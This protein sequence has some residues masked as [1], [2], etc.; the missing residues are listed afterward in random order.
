VY[1]HILTVL[2]STWLKSK[3]QWKCTFKLPFFIVP[4]SNTVQC[5]I[6]FVTWGIWLFYQW[7]D[8]L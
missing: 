4:C 8:W 1:G 7:S 5:R 3:K 2:A 6:N